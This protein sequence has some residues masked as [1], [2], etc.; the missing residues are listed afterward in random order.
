MEISPD[1]LSIADL[2]GLFTLSIADLC[3]LFT[4]ITL[5]YSVPLVSL[6][7]LGQGNNRSIYLSQKNNSYEKD[8]NL[9]PFSRDAGPAGR[10]CSYA[11]HICKI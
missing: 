3:G 1:E 6:V 2:C 8:G 11:G 10:C 9:S 5:R 7:S 4:P